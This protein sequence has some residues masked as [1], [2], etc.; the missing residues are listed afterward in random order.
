[1]REDNGQKPATLSHA[2]TFLIN[3]GR[4]RTS[5]VSIGNVK[6][7]NVGEDA[8]NGGDIRGLTNVP[9]R[10]AHAVFGD[11]IN[12]GFAADLFLDE[13]FQFTG[14]AINQKD[15]AGLRIESLDMTRPI[16]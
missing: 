9:G 2:L 10:M 16:I 3:P 6:K 4:R 13:L 15:R 8:L 7:R 14:R 5:V 1:M 12:L 11:K